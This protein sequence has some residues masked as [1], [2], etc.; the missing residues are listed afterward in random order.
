MDI[1]ALVTQITAWS[2]GKQIKFY[3]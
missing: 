3:I 2:S 1:D